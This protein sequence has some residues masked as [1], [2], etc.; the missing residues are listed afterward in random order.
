MYI[1]HTFLTFWLDEDEW[2]ASGSDLYHKEKALLLTKVR[3]PA[4]PQKWSELC[5]AYPKNQTSWIFHPLSSRC[6]HISCNISLINEH[7]NINTLDPIKTPINGQLKRQVRSYWFSEIFK[8]RDPRF[9]H[10]LSSL[11]A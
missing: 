7:I 2:L 4:G 9:E 11:V 8:A 1:V 3:G 5:V 6:T 10:S